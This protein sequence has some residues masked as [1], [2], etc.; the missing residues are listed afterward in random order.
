MTVL[1]DG[2]QKQ[3]IDFLFPVHDSKKTRVNQNK[4]PNTRT[5]VFSYLFVSIVPQVS[6]LVHR[7]DPHPKKNGNRG[8]LRFN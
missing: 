4:T 6:V 2:G 1:D 3:N 7:V 8:R 5:S